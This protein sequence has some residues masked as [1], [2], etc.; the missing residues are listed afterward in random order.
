MVLG[1]L[2]M[3]GDHVVWGRIKDF[4]RIILETRWTCEEASGF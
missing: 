1:T 4:V 3:Y 2:G